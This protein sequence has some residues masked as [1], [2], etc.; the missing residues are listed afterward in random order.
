MIGFEVRGH[1]A[2]ITL[3]RPQARNAVDPDTTRQI[4]DAFDRIDNDNDI[5]VAII[6]GA[7]PVFCAGADLRA[8]NAGQ[9]RELSDA[10]GFASLTYRQRTK[11][12]IA[13]VN[14]PA[15]AGGTEIVLACDLVVAEASA[16]FGIPEVKRGLIA[17]AGGLYRLARVLPRNIALECGMTGD[18]LS[19]SRAAEFG[20]VN[21]L[22][23]HGEALP[24]AIHLAERI[25]ANA[26]L[27][28]SETRRLMLSTSYEPDEVG[29][30][31][32]RK[33]MKRILASKDATEG[34][35]AF[36][37]KRAPTWTGE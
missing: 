8:I 13:A 36:V 5:R 25:T 24:T 33:A 27:A 30:T 16:T 15:L 32:S 6:T 31:E 10:N 35:R 28:V 18:P 3:N 37:E 14:G 11:P 29:Y 12:L 4:A 21:V 20:L 9:E 1:H 23:E 34:V 7:P 19:A 26:P 17:A 22:A 2:V